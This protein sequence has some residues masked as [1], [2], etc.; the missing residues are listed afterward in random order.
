[1]RRRR[2]RRGAR[3]RRSRR[4]ADRVL[5]R[6]RPALVR[7]ERGEVTGIGLVRPAGELAQLPPFWEIGAVGVEI[8][9]D[10]DTGRITVEHLVTVGDVGFAINP[11]LVE[12]QDLGAATQGLGAALHEE[13]VYD[14]PQLVNPNVVDYHVPRAKDMPRRIDTLLA[15]RGDGVGPRRC[16]GR[17][18]GLA[19]PR[20]ARRRS[21]GGTSHRALAD[22]PAVD[23]GTGV[24]VDARP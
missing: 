5:R 17:G 3:R 21:G 23:P 6:D 13:L 8:S 9:I 15:E 7:R 10:P 4:R 24:A 22:A 16:E 18:R 20:R 19:Q 12:G 11:T 14:G 1:M 2:A